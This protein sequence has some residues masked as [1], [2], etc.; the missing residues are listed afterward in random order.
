MVDTTAASWFFVLTLG[1]LV[2]TALLVPGAQSLW[3][4]AGVVLAVAGV[5]LLPGVGVR[6]VVKG[7]VLEIRHLLLTTRVPLRGASARTAR[8]G[9]WRRLGGWEGVNGRHGRFVF[10][11]LPDLALDVRGTDPRGTV[12]VLERRGLPPL[13]L[14]P[15]DPDGLVE[16][17]RGRAPA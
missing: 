3:F 11:A 13:V 1:V 5:A 17:L 6:Y 7:G 9:R 10:E 16:A 12:V 8:L 15:I 4:S 2:F 14:T